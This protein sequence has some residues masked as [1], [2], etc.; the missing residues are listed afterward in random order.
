MTL[1]PE[2]KRGHLGSDALLYLTAE[3]LGKIMIVPGL[4]YLLTFLVGVV[5]GLIILT[6]LS[7]EPET[8]V[9]FYEL[10][11]FDGTDFDVF[12]SLA[13]QPRNGSREESTECEATLLQVRDAHQQALDE[14]TTNEELVEYLSGLLEQ[15]SP[16][17]P[18]EFPDTLDETFQPENFEVAISEL[19]LAC[20]DVFTPETRV[21]C[22]EYPCIVEIPIAPDLRP[23]NGPFQLNDHCS[24]V[25][26]YLPS[27]MAHSFE[28]TVG[29]VSWVQY[30]PRGTGIGLDQHTS[31]DPHRLIQRGL[32]RR[33]I[34]RE[35]LATHLYEEACLV[36]RQEDACR[37]MV[38]AFYENPTE[39]ETFMQIGCDVGDA[40]SCHSY[41]YSR[42]V[43]QGLCDTSAENFARRAIEL[44]PHSGVYRYTLAIILCER[45]QSHEANR[46]FREGCD[47]GFDLACQGMCETSN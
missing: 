16:D 2:G 19:M 30:M 4:K 26:T 18:L 44:T 22:S 42:C 6:F 7:E 41:A 3:E 1:Y 38:T 15:M 25:R 46:Q 27:P 9:E 36:E 31:S 37:E 32:E 12:P 45:N 13:D 24:E 29:D 39:R 33:R 21:D 23:E 28:T 10:A 43:S 17:I 34:L 5:V 11:D 40:Q 35:M 20:P 8:F 47:L 14:H